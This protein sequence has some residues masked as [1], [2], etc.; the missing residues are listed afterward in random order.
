MNLT[1]LNAQHQYSVNIIG[2]AF[3]CTGE[4]QKVYSANELNNPVWNISGGTIISYPSASEVFVEWHSPT[5]TISVQDSYSFTV[6]ENVCI[7]ETECY[8]QCNSITDNYSGYL[9]V[10]LLQP[11]IQVSPASTVCDGTPIVLT[12]IPA[13]ANCQ[14]R[15]DGVNILGANQNLLS[16]NSSGQYSVQVSFWGCV[17]ESS[18]VSLSV[19]M[20]P[21]TPYLSASVSQS[22]PGAIQLQAFNGNN[23]VWYKDNVKVSNSNGPAILQAIIPGSYKVENSNG[24]CGTFS[25]SIEVFNSSIYPSIVTNKIKQANIANEVQIEGFAMQPAVVQ[26]T[27]NYITK[28]GQPLQTILRSNSPTGKDILSVYEYD[29]LGKVSKSY[30]PISV[31][32]NTGLF[33]T[34]VF[35]PV[36]SNSKHFQFY[37]DNSYDPSNLIPNDPNPF[38]VSINENSPLNRVVEQ[39]QIGEGFQPTVGANNSKTTRFSFGTNSQ[40]EV[41]QFSIQEFGSSFFIIEKEYYLANTLSKQIITTPKESAMIEFINSS[42]K[43]VLRKV[44]L[45]LNTWAETYFV[46]DMQDNLRFILTPELVKYIQDNNLNSISSEQPLN[47]ITSNTSLATTNNSNAYPYQNGASITLAPGFTSANG[48]IAKPLGNTTYTINRYAYQF[49]YDHR[50]RQI[51]EKAPGADWTYFIYDIQDRPILT[52]PPHLRA[53][54]QWEFT[55]YD[56]FQRVILTGFVTLTQTVAELRALVNNHSVLYEEPSTTNAVHGYTNLAFPNQPN[57]NLYQSVVYYDN[58][59]C[60]S[61][62]PAGTTWTYQPNLLS[63]LPAQAHNRIKGSVTGTK[64]K[65]VGTTDWLYATQYYDEWG[66]VIQSIGTN[67]LGGNDI[68]STQYDFTGKVLATRLHHNNGQQQYVITE[69]FEY[70]AVGRT[71]RH[72]HQL[73]NTIADRVLLE[74]FAYNELGDLVTHKLHRKADQ[75]FLQT[76]QLRSNIRGQLLSQTSEDFQQTL[77]YDNTQGLPNVLPSYAG[78]ISSITTMHNVSANNTQYAWTFNYDKQSQLT[79]SEQ[80]QKTVAAN[81]WTQ[82]V[83]PI[84]ESNFSYD[85]NGNIQSLTRSGANGTIDNLQYNYGIGNAKGNQL[86]SISDAAQKNDGFKDGNTTGNDYVYDVAGNL[87]QDLNKN[88]GSITY[89]E[90]NLTHQ[91]TVTGVGYL[92]YLYTADGTKLADLLYSHTNQLLKRTDYATPFIYEQDFTQGNQRKLHSIQTTTGRV[93][94]IPTGGYEYQYVLTDHLGSARMI[95]SASPRTY[96]YKATM[97]TANATAEE[98]LFTNVTETRV[99]AIPTTINQT[100]GGSKVA[101]L[102]VVK[103][104]GP[105]LSL[106]VF[107]GDVINANVYV[108]H[109]GS[110]Y[111]NTRITMTSLISALVGAFGGGTLTPSEAA[112]LSN[113]FEANFNAE[114]LLA[115]P[116]DN[117]PAA[118]LNFIVFDLEM[119]PIDMGYTRAG[120]SS[121]VISRNNITITEPGYIYLYVS[122][123]GSNSTHVYFDDFTV[124]L[125]ES[126]LCGTYHN[127]PFGASIA[128][129]QLERW[130][131]PSN[132]YR[133]QGK[134]YEDAMGIKLHDFH[135]RLYGAYEARWFAMDPAGQFSS[136]Y[137]AMGN[138][139]LIGIDPDGK[140]LIPMLIGAIYGA[141]VSSSIAWANHQNIEKAAFRGAIIGA[142]SAAAAT[143]A[144]GLVAATLSP[145]NTVAGSFLSG[146]ASGSVGGFAGGFVSGM[147]NELFN[148]GNLNTSFGAGWR[149][150][151]LGALSGFLFGGLSGIDKHIRSN[152]NF[153]SSFDK[154]NIS[155]T[156]D[157]VRAED[158][159][160]LKAQKVWYPKAP[161]SSIKRFTVQN[162]PTRNKIELQAT[163]AHGITKPL[164]D[165]QKRLTGESNVYF[166]E[167]AFQNA[168]VLFSTMGHEFV[169][170]SQIA[171]LKGQM[172][173][174][175]TSQ[176]KDMMEYHAYSFSNQLTGG[177]SLKAN[178]FTVEEIKNFLSMKFFNEMNFVN[179]EWRLSSRFVYPGY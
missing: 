122:N 32:Q 96:T 86:L 11:S 18:N 69:E 41:L 27:I 150:G 168:K 51:A 123:E 143:V 24:T 92:T 94:P 101:A 126:K 137:N 23:Y 29:P 36:Y 149:T 62:F 10:N 106:Q 8:E 136:P 4:I 48:F 50:N 1:Q 135:A 146:A 70:D 153:Y 35:N 151:K 128:E 7:T 145:G 152:A 56:R 120:S 87:T 31:N 74:E 22:A 140:I 108:N 77:G 79:G 37:N 54:N 103:P 26:Q 142:A 167:S 52:Q 89:N 40:Y 116:T 178:S 130:R 133:Y 91:I 43:T 144:G 68:S 162:V 85:L 171:A 114:G 175:F 119:N 5:G 170:V 12:A 155:S 159:F 95:L 172:Y 19:L 47:L 158:D 28:Q 78:E 134:Q 33:V 138:S 61:S 67:H 176:F 166:A 25:N 57:E 132:Q 17:S 46:Y 38:A 55:K 111:G 157:P 3:Y 97:E 125:N 6:C 58:Y 105:A 177:V 112:S 117:L 30:L 165:G 110:G 84:K 53:S 45:G 9:E 169:H 66:R 104:I 161:M 21:P 124:T 127:Y 179:Y 34:D 99:D 16:V 60:L 93:L 42:G 81:V 73:G 141:L 88:I 20:T 71:L 115:A 100:P 160:L 64:I 118:Y 131:M 102:N 59:A 13:G 121:G 163:K 173:T 75:S 113:S 129:L 72:F 174:I 148:G 63:N 164:M 80:W 44:Q 147:G 39:G 139:P 65:V 109:A 90:L 49:A 83:N 154:L 76:I 14:W 98:M 15:K 2:D 156:W 107:P 82:P